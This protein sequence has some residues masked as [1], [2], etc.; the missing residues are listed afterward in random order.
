METN[1]L[2]NV[3]PKDILLEQI[4]LGMSKREMAK[5]LKCDRRVVDKS[6]TYYGIE[7][8]CK[9]EKQP[10]ELHHNKQNKCEICG[11]FFDKYAII[12]GKKVDLRK[13]NHCLDCLPYKQGS[14]SLRRKESTDT[15]CKICGKPLKSKK[16]VYCSG[17]CFHFDLYQEY[18]QRW[19]NGEED[20]I[21]GDQW[22]DIS[23][24]IKR[25]IFE[26]YDYK[27]AKCGW[28]ERNP[29]TNTLPLEIEHIDGNALN[30]DESNLTLLCP[31][32]HSLTKTYRG[33][34]K[35]NGKRNIKWLSRSGKD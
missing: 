23:T 21:I 29:Y 32:C 1:K 34:N 20:G 13:R 10:V 15:F 6:L 31:N 26:K 11:K 25:Y 7:Y 22:K 3:I 24:Y 27:C 28:A 17:T 33:A 8:R 9:K 2:K 16:S 14:G 30:N 5:E 4:A 12:D 35:G 19:K 18:I